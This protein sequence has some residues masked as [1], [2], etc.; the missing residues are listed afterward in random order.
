M[1]RGKVR[2]SWRAARILGLDPSLL[3]AVPTSALGQKAARPLAAGLRTERLRAM[4]IP[5]KGV[6]EGVRAFA[7]ARAAAAR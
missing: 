6:D 3:D 4:G 7:A 1:G 2:A 5:M